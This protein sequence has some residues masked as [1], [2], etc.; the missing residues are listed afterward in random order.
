MSTKAASISRGVSIEE[1]V[2]SYWVFLARNRYDHH[3]DKF[4]RRLE[5]DA[6]AAE[7]EAVVFALLWAAKTRPDIFE[8]PSKGGPDFCCDP[9]GKQRF[10]VEVTSL[11]SG[12]VSRRSGLPARIEGNGGGAFGLITAALSGAAG[13]KAAQ[14]A[15][16]PYPRVLAITS[17]HAFASILM[18][19]L[20]AEN[21]LVSDPMI[22]H[23]LG[24]FNGYGTITTDLRRAV[25]FRLDRSGRQIVP[26]RQSISAILLVAISGRQADVVGVLHPQPAIVFDP[27]LFPQVP[28]LR[29]SHWPIVDGKLS[30][31]WSIGGDQS[32]AFYHTR[33]R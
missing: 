4:K 21:L 31:E 16:Q 15:D 20:P 13:S 9:S 26:R 2:D 25:F 22:S 32:A 11:E 14:L 24:D 17:S 30:T 28:Y 23:R 29:L 3:L 1:V 8:D 6:N 10:L 18:D 33:I 5:T 27:N 12:A 19:R 7:A